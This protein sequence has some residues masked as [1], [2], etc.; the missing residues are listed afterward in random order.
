MKS[1][2][3][4]II[5]VN[6]ISEVFDFLKLSKPKHPL[7][8]LMK[9]EEMPPFSS[10]GEKSWIWNFYAISLKNGE[11]C[12]VQYGQNY[13]DF[14]E[15]ELSFFAPKQILTKPES[16]Q[17][18]SG[19]TLLF[20]PDFIRNSSLAKKIK[21]YG[22][23]SYSV[24]EA[25][26]MSEKEKKIIISV[27]EN[28][29]YE[30]NNSID[31]FSQDVLISQIEVL[32]NYSIRFYKRQ[33]ITR[34][35]VNH[36]LLTRMEDLLNNYF[37]SETTLKQGLP[38]VE[39]LASQLNMSP[40]YLSDMLRSLTG[41]NTQQHIHEKLIE[42]AKEKLSTTNLSVSE[43]AYELGFE[44]LQSFSK[45]FKTKTKLSPL[46]FRQSFN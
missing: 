14:T 18:I 17:N 35:A 21:N 19:Y 9:L 23:F 16:S 32:L 10:F 25:L 5:T 28:I 13:Y 37:D 38:T 34:K 45:L 15:G 7:I 36:D 2:K 26:F 29:N 20:H 33:F 43:I 42:I 46:E 30:L 11:R 3:T 31:D 41:Q 12:K 44:Y 27:F 40:R 22:F 8:G 24:N 1:K 6:S 39:Y 4:N